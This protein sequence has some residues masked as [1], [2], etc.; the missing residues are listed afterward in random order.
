MRKKNL[1][2][3]FRWGIF[4]VLLLFTGILLSVHQKEEIDIPRNTKWSERMALS[5]MLRNPEPWQLDFRETPKWEYTQGLVLKSLEKLADES[6]D[7]KF[8]KYVEAYADFMINE[9]GEIKTYNIR[10]F[11]I[12]RINPGRIL[13]KLN[14]QGKSE[15]YEI[16]LKTLR[17]QLKWQPRTTEGAFWHKLRYPW[18]IWLDGL[19]MGSPFYAQYAQVYNEPEA[20]DDI[21]N[22]F[23]ISEKHTKDKA[24]GLLY[25]G[26]DESHLQ[27]WANKS[28]GTSLN[29]WGRAMGWYAMALVDVLDYFPENHPKRAEII[30][31]L[32][33]TVEVVIQYQDKE[34]G[35]WYQVL[36]M[37]SK[38][39][40]YLE[41]SASCMFVYAIA[42]AVNKE[43]IEGKY[44]KNAEMGFEGILKEFIEVNE[45]NG[46]VHIHQVCSVAGLGGD[47]NR[48]GTFEYYINEPK[49]SN[50]TKATGPF[51]QACLELDR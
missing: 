51:I 23:I 33:R 2:S 41:A 13:F 1:I 34:S 37:G 27:D 45:A 46:E 5:I 8:Q 50:D 18:Q 17:N 15:K 12:D 28:T 19:Y 48:S 24:T 31:I 6:K 20:F 40:N 35:L 7:D 16:A 42:K 11:N 3:T 22:Q 43:Y 32:K 14:E 39:G 49:R 38:E 25:H 10:D 44:M 9:Q 30:N 4:P 26:W 29:F 47:G 21:A 36:D